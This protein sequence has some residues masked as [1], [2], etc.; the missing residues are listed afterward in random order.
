MSS[1]GRSITRPSG[2]RDQPCG[3][4][5]RRAVEAL[6]TVTPVLVARSTGGPDPQS[7]RQALIG[8]AFN[9]PRRDTNQPDEIANALRWIKEA[10]LRIS[11]FDD[12]DERAKI[13]RKA[14]DACAKTIDGGPAAATTTRRKRSVLYNALGYAVELGHLSANPVDRVQWTAPDIAETVDRR[15]VA[16]AHQARELLTAVSYVGRTRGP[17]LVAFFGLLYFAAL[18]PSEAVALCEQDCD[19]PKEGWGKLILSVS[20]PQAGKAWT[21]DGEYRQV[22]EVA[23]QERDSCGADSA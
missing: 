16:S 4:V 11:A 23:R 6:A 9:P 20:E 10:S 19:L 13:T 15:V 7:L 22:S 12:P 8:W 5:I 2:D 3:R 17:H 14:L 1:T 21:D 18:R